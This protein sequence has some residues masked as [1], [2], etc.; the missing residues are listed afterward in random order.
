MGHPE[1]KTDDKFSEEQMY[2]YVIDSDGK[3]KSKRSEQD[4]EKK[5]KI[6][7]DRGKIK[8]AINDARIEVY[9]SHG[10]LN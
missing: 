3:M 7:L 10:D 6:M 2:G 5:P 1:K 8:A 9:E 4:P